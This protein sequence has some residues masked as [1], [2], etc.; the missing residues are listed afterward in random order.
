MKYEYELLNPDFRVDNIGITNVSRDK[1]YKHSYR[2]GRPKNGFVYTVKGKI[3]NVFY[4]ENVATIDT[5]AGDL[6]FIPKGCSYVTTYLEDDTE[7]KIVQF[8]LL[9]GSFPSYLQGPTKIDLLGAGEIMDD[10]FKPLKNPASNHPLYY[11]SKLYELLWQI[12]K[13]QSGTSTKYKKL[14]P[15]LQY[16]SEHYAVNQPISFYAELC[17]MSEVNFRRV[18]KDYV[19]TSPTEYRND[20]RLDHAKTMIGSGEYNVSEAAQLCGFSNL[21]FF[22]RLYKKKYGHTPKKE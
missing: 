19:G 21:S 4:G 22:I 1:N 10:F 16:I 13:Q 9:S 2:A 6:V 7:L 17:D 5:E 8:D 18:F 20:V 3:H 11:L 12:T 15:A 14:R